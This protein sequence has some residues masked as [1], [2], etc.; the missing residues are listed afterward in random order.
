[1]K[2]VMTGFVLLVSVF[3]VVGAGYA[4]QL[5]EKTEQALIDAMNDEYK[6][7]A[8][9]QK[10]IETFGEVRPFSNIIKAEETHIELLK[11]LFDHYGVDVPEDTWY[12]KVPEFATLQAACGAGVTA[13]I[14]N[15]KLYDEFLTFVVEPDILEVFTYLRNAS[16]EKHLPAFQRCTERSNGIGS[17]RGNGQRRRN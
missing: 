7:R 10:V 2:R 16:Q 6:A 4:Q 14:E 11:P 5:D 13:E 8:T 9:Y 17:G 12:A 3:A 15:A 1:M